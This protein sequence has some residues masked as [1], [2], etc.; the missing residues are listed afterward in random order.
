MMILSRVFSKWIIFK[1]YHNSIVRTVV[2]ATVIA[3]GIAAIQKPWMAGTQTH[4][5]DWIPAS[6]LE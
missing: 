2:K 4:A 1:G 3:A 5:C 6:M